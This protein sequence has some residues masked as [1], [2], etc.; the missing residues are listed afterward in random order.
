MNLEFLKAY[1]EKP[2]NRRKIALFSFLS[3][4]LLTLTFSE[5][6]L[7]KRLSLLSDHNSLRYDMYLLKQETD[8]LK[9]EISN[10]RTNNREI[11]RL[12]R[13]DFGLVKKGENIIFFQSKK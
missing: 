4:V 9:K 6:G 13:E 2:E 1:A 3:F 11:E 12:A 7:Y 10:L 8:S 5:Y